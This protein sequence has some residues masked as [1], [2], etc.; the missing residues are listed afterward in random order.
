MS[1][2][3]I[4][5][6]EVIMNN[7]SVESTS[8]I[9]RLRRCRR[10]VS[11]SSSG[12]KRLPGQGKSSFVGLSPGAN[13][14][15]PIVST[16]SALCTELDTVALVLAGGRGSRLGPLTQ[17]CC[18]PA[19]PFGA[20]NRIIDYTLSNCVNSGIRRIGII[21]QYQQ[22]SLIQHVQKS[23]AFLQNN[24]QEFV[25][26]LPVQHVT[27]EDFYK[28]TADAVFK[29]RTLLEKLSPRFTLVLAGDHIY[30]ADYRR[31]ISHHM[32]NDADLTIACCTVPLAE[33]HNY[34]IVSTDSHHRVV[35][36][37]EKPAC[38]TPL[39]NGS[40]LAYA[41][42]GFYLFNTQHLLDAFSSTSN[43][44]SAV[45]DFAR[46][47]IPSMLHKRRVIG[48]DFS[49]A[50]LENYWRDVGTLD[51]YF[52]AN[53][54]LLQPD[55]VMNTR[56][57][58]WP[59]HSQ[60]V[61]CEPTRFTKSSKGYSGL[62]TD[63][64]VAPGCIV[65]GSKLRHSILYTNV[66]VD[67]QC[68]IENALLLPGVRIGKRCR[69]R[70]A[71]INANT[72]VP[73]DTD[74]GYGAECKTLRHTVTDAGVVVVSADERDDASLEYLSTTPSV[75]RSQSATKKRFAKQT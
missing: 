13:S 55:A 59:I 23:W 8:A 21:T 29:N 25:D 32:A 28:G 48:Y 52:E 22:S 49:S 61:T 12:S 3:F 6:L 60:S 17:S 62:T 73:N 35:D 5:L 67:E 70:N 75:L 56:N 50:Q 51:T 45:H 42:M 69:I 46:D 2:P 11:I 38:P 64:I 14:P 74:I 20:G 39:A 43:D 36:F 63:C 41:S 68:T 18:K 31:M 57:E 33:A 71:I 58:R 44:A 30:K 27:G 9:G 4:E 24:D 53:M 15:Q 7:A 16:P 66:H 40:D 19:V 54:Q 37:N 34:G 47:V 10:G 26:L 72:V 1:V 65:K